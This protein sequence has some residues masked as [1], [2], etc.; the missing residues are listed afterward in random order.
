MDEPERGWSLS[1]VG[2]GFLNFYH[3][4]VTRCLRERAPHLLRDARMLFGSSSGA[5][6]CAA[7]L[8]G[9]PLD[10]TIQILTDLFRTVRKR[11]LGVLHPSVNLSKCVREELHKCLPANV[12]QLVSDKMG[13]SLTRVSDWKNVLVSDFQSKDEVVDVLVCSTFLPVYCGLIPP[14]FRGVRYVDGGFTDDVPFIDAKTTITISPFYGE[15]DICPK[16]KSKNS[17]NVTLGKLNL[18]VCFENAYLLSATVFPPF[19]KVL[20]EMCFQ[21]YLDALRFLKEQGICTRPGP[22]LNSSSEESASEVMAPCW[23]SRG[24]EPPRERAAGETRP[25]G[26]ELLDHL[27]LSMRERLSPQ[28]TTALR[29]ALRDG[30]AFRSELRSLFPL[31]VLSLVLLPLEC[32]VALVHRSPAPAPGHQAIPHGP[33]HE[34][35]CQLPHA[36]RRLDACS[37]HRP[38]GPEAEAAQRSFLNLA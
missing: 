28:R 15:F 24:L 31:R 3:V 21:G 6:H 25:E 26:A 20:G 1:F 35:G 27:P 12:H 11:S 19:L 23:E 36:P 9:V 17:F 22:S 33:E 2:C 37:G 29:E 38:E 14:S 30:G 10:Q 34:R 4:G 32:V 16:V 7:L 13:I 5:L 18:H 8:A